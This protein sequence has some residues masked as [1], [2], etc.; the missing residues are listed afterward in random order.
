[1]NTAP[2]HLESKLRFFWDLSVGQ[3][4]AAFA[5]IM[6][7]VVWAKFV[8]PLHGMLGAMT[9][10]YI[11]A[12]PVIPVFV[13]SQTEFDLCGLVIG[14]ARWRRLDGRYVPGAGQSVCGYLLSGE[15]AADPA[16]DPDGV[17]LDLQ[18]LW[19]DASPTPGRHRTRHAGVL[20]AS[21]PDRRRTE[22][23]AEA[24][25]EASNRPSS[26]SNGKEKR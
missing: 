12:L 11:A 6:L 25:R 20:L 22:H 1:M 26:M 9:G 23:G 19:E 15:Q 14:A 24:M 21:A 2:A 13:A 3:I 16:G 18:V 7:G 4:A 5:G 10:A 17:G 8:S